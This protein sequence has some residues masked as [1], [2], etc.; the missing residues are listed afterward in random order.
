MW[1]LDMSV[2]HSIFSLVCIVLE[3]F[4]GRSSHSDVVLRYLPLFIHWYQLL[5]EAVA[6]SRAV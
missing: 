1:A 5:V 3:L 6:V 2:G 4:F